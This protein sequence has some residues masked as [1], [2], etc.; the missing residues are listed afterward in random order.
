MGITGSP[1]IF[2]LKV[3]NLMIVLESVWVYLDDLYENDCIHGKHMPLTRVL[4]QSLQDKTDLGTSEGEY[5]DDVSEIV[6]CIAFLKMDEMVWLTL[7]ADW[8]K[9]ELK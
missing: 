6:E 7:L 5:F 3:A 2:Q 4:S 9:T 8:K 1:D